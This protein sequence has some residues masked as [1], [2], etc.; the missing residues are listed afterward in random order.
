MN[1]KT[2]YLLLAP[3]SLILIGAGLCFAIESAFLKHD[4]PG[5]YQWVLFGTISLIVFNA[6]ICLFGKAVIIK[7]STLKQKDN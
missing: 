7:I 6:G 1:S 2:K 3:F 5:S 4:N